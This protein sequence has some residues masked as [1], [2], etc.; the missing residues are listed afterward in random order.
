M[1]KDKNKAEREAREAVDK[2]SL[3]TPGAR[4]LAKRVDD[5]AAQAVV[6]EVKRPTK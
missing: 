5:A 6:D 1:G 3:G 4:E 2:S